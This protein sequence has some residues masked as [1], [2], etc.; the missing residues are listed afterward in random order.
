MLICSGD[1]AD[2]QKIST[3]MKFGFERALKLFHAHRWTNPHHTSRQHSTSENPCIKRGARVTETSLGVTYKIRKKNDFRVKVS[4]MQKFT[5][6]TSTVESSRNNFEI[7]KNASPKNHQRSD[8]ESTLPDVT[9]RLS[10][11]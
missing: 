6:R 9:S 11:P 2:I 10:K 4:D 7:E 5:A 8:H 1:G 3:P